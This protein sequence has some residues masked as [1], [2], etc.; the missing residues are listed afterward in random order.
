VLGQ[1]YE[2]ENSSAARALELIGER[3]S[4]LIIRNALR[5]MHRF[6][7][8]QRELGIAPNVLAKRLKRFLDT[9]LME[10]R[11]TSD[12]HSHHVY[13]L[14]DKGRDLALVIIALTEW[15][16]RWAAPDGP[17]VVHEPG[18]CDGSIRLRLGCDTCGQVASPRQVSTLLGPGA[19]PPN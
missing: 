10:R 11:R 7:D 18:H 15:G 16:D 4:L 2:H 13:V 1:T 3:W 19:S 12:P 9:D 17:P 14:T 5:G 8:F 6:S